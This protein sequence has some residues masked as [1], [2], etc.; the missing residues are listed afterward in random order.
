M[1]VQYKQQ[2]NKCKKNYVIANYRERYVV[3]YECQKYDMQGEITD[4]EMKKFF[5]IPDE[6]YMKN[7]FLRNIK[8]NYLRYG[9]LSEKQIEA[10]KN[11]VEKMSKKE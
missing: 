9:K 8:I 10:F 6:F 1:A 3:C 2:C 11:T 5:D 4:P 7:L